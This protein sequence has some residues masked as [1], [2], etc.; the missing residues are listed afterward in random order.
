M[1]RKEIVNIKHKKITI[2]ELTVSQVHGL[3]LAGAGIHEDIAAL[4]LS[5]GMDAKKIDRI[6]ADP[7]SFKNIWEAFQRVN[8]ALFGAGGTNKQSPTP[9]NQSTEAIID[10]LEG[11]V[12]RLIMAG[13]VHVF[14]YGFSFFLTAIS[15][16]AGKRPLFKL[17]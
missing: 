2:S 17:E 9:K 1:V 7:A 8:Q 10:N 16:L 5:T 3:L 15:H 4:E 11:N 12:C 13:H 14:D 6:A